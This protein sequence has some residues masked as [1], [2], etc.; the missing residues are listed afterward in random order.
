LLLTTNSFFADTDQGERVALWIFLYRVM[1]PIVLYFPYVI[2]LKA[3]IAT[4]KLQ[5]VK[6]DPTDLFLK[7]NLN[8]AQIK[9]ACLS[10][11]AVVV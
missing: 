2:N 9:K 6:A 8:E 3:F 1:K 4:E 7:T 5:D 11:G 10:Y